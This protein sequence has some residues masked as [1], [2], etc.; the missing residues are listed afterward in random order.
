M[1][2]GYRKSIAYEE[3]YEGGIRKL[4]G[5]RRLILPAI[6]AMVVDENGAILLIR[7]SDN[8]KWG[9]PA[10]ALELNES[11]FEC[12]V[13]EVDEETGLIVES[14]IPFAINS[15]KRFQ[16]TNHYGNKVQMLSTVFIIEKWS[17]T[18]VRQTDETLDARFFSL[19][20]LPELP[21]HYEETIEDYRKYLDDRQFILK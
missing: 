7:R 18:L 20:N 9:F 8:K 1:S 5:N 17:G 3:T 21:P 19:E 12:L 11:L 6:R 10:G 13:R 15:E 2:N 16:Y 14:A 4:I